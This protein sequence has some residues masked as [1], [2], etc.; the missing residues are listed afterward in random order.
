VRPPW[1]EILIG[2]LCERADSDRSEYISPAE[3]EFI[4]KL[5]GHSYP[6]S[7]EGVAMRLWQRRKRPGFMEYCA[8]TLRELETT[9]NGGKDSMHVNKDVGLALVC[10]ACDADHYLAAVKLN[11]ENA[12]R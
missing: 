9:A 2:W 1:R 8:V 12:D 11:G 10:L 5:M 6:L 7:D 3:A 4:L